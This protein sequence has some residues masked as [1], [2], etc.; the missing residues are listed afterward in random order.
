M[1]YL[2]V[3]FMC[4]IHR[5]VGLIFKQGSLDFEFKIPGNYTNK[6]INQSINLKHN[7]HHKMVVYLQIQIKT[8]K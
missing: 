7:A 4:R 6:S 5:G 8:F 2:E 3:L 1:D